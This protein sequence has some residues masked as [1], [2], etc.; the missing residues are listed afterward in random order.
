MPRTIYDITKSVHWFRTHDT[1]TARYD[2]SISAR[3]QIRA[4]Q[5]E[6]FDYVL[7]LQCALLLPVHS[8]CQSLLVHD[9][10]LLWL[11]RMLSPQGLLWCLF[12]V[13]YPTVV[14][15]L[16]YIVVVVASWYCAQALREAGTE[17]CK[18]NLVLMLWIS[19]KSMDIVY[20][21]LVRA[22]L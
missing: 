17:G 1:L 15:L 10:S 9:I 7:L 16:L 8:L 19:Y 20:K 14:L 18:A 12:G 22:S 13:A 11:A 4:A 5:V 6:A 2:M 21:P 3:R